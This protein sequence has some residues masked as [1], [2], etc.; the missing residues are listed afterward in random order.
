MASTPAETPTLVGPNPVRRVLNPGFM[1]HPADST[2]QR[3]ERCTSHG[4]VH[5]DFLGQ[6]ERNIK[7]SVPAPPMSC[8]QE[9][10]GSP[11]PSLSVAPLHTAPMLPKPPTMQAKNS[12]ES[13]REFR[14]SPSKLAAVDR[15]LEAACSLL[16]FALGEVSTINFDTS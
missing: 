12:S 1:A 11:Q 16:Q 14:H 10:T 4:S 15:C 9:A 2:V 5:Q 7:Y 13:L 6:T 8:A 3:L